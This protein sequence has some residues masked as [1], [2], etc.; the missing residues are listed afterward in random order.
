VRKAEVMGRR[1]NDYVK[2][3][4]GFKLVVRVCETVMNV[5]RLRKRGAK[6]F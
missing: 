2:E 4:R 1:L 6:E 3:V 5:W